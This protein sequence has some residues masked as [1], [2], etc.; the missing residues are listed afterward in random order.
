M[1][2]KVKVNR[3]KFSA[4][5]FLKEPLKCSHLHG[6]NYYMSVELSSELDENYFVVDF[7][8]LKKKVKLVTKSLDHYVL[9]PENSKSI[10]IKEVD[11]TVE[12]MTN[13]NKRYVFP[14][15][16]VTF[17]PLEATTSELLAQYLHGKIKKIYPDKRVKVILEESKSAMAIYEE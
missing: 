1:P 11:D 13:T 16:D 8:D 12:I 2:F 17:L 14:K 7:I 15:S 3:I 10:V 6:H 5:H 4:S 9:I